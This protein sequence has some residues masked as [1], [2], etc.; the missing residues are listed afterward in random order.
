MNPSGLCKCG[1]GQVTRVA[2]QDH[3]RSGHVKGQHV[4]Y[5]KNHHRIGADFSTV[6]R[7]R[8]SAA[9]SGARASGWKGSSAGY[10]A[11]HSW[12]AMHYPKLGMCGECGEW[13]RTEYA[14]IHGRTFSRNPADWLELC[15]P[16]H[17]L[18]D[19]GGERSPGALL[20]ESHVLSILNQLAAGAS[21][22]ALA[23]EY[24]VSKSAIG[25]ISSGR[26]WKHL[27]RKSK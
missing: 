17:K 6:H 2:T 16:C 8:L 22:G 21:H 26:T 20:K 24:G 15:I 10:R 11:I 14:V 13:D 7:A 1:C 19:L 18:Y 12:M 5:V 27:E 23:E 9:Q 25:A 4:D 3:S